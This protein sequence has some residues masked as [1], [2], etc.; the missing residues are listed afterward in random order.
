MYIH[1]DDRFLIGNALIDA[2]HRMLVFL[3]RKLDLAIKSGELEDSIRKILVEVRKFSEFHFISE[4]NLMRE[5]GYPRL[6]EHEHLHSQLLSQLDVL[7]ARL[8][9]RKEFPDEILYFLNTWLMAHIGKEDKPISQ[10]ILTT[11]HSPLGATAYAE[12]FPVLQ[13]S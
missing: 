5:I 12:Y 13:E 4:E 2:E 11:S 7:I 3:F 1:W 8:G 6:H 9:R 10:H